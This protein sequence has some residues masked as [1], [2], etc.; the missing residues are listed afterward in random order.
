MFI[1]RNQQFKL[2]DFGLARILST[3]TQLAKTNVGTPY[4]MARS[5][6][7]SSRTTKNA[8]SGPWDVSSTKW[9]LLSVSQPLTHM[10]N[11]RKARAA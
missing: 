11:T 6:S 4:Y 8:T 7:M 3:D 1:D 5:K 10:T 2:G 9:L